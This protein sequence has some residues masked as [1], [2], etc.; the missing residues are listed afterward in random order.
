VTALS[1][2]V[3]WPSAARIAGVMGPRWR[4]SSKALTNFVEHPEVGADR[5]ERVAAVFRAGR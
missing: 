1:G 5:I 4:A 2:W 3:Q